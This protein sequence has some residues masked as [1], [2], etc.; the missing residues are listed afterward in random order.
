MTR[1]VTVHYINDPQAPT[2]Q[3]TLIDGN[4]LAFDIPNVLC[5][6]I[7]VRGYI[8][9]NQVYLDA[10]N[11]VELTDK[12]PVDQIEKLTLLEYIRMVAR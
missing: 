1:R 6:R 7:I 3:A 12:I 10:Y 8:D 5:L 11:E 9:G 2:E 4:L